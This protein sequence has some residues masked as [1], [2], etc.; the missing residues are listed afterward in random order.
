MK[1]TLSVEG[2]HCKSCSH[3]ISLQLKKLE[4]VDKCEIDFPTAQMT[5]DFDQQ[6]QSL[7]TIN[8]VISPLGYSVHP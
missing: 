6:K 3:L 7:E 1:Q 5:I 2:M 4:G 8:N